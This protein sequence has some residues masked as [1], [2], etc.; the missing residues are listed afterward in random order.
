MF[1]LS[2]ARGTIE[3]GPSGLHDAPDVPR[4]I[5]RSARRVFPV[6]HR[7]T[8]LEIAQF[9]VRRPVVAQGRSSRLNRLAQ[10][11][12]DMRNKGFCPVAR[13]PVTAARR[14][15]PG[16]VER[17]AHIDIAKPGNEFLV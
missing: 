9:A 1:K 11:I 4:A 5:R 15:D 3:T 8:M 10:N 13:D 7:E 2:L 12:A 17:L 6:I 14:R 16:T